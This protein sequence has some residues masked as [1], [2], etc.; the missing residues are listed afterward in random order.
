MRKKIEYALMLL[1]I[2]GVTYW[3]VSGITLITDVKENVSVQIYEKDKY[4]KDSI[5]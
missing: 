5:I 2:A 3:I 1:I 4:A